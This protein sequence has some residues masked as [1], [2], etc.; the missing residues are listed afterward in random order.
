MAPPRKWR[1]LKCD[2]LEMK[3]AKEENV[4]KEYG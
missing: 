3:R 2:D 1:F 4:I